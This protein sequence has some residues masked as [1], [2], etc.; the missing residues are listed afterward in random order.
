MAHN[1]QSAP[2]P[3]WSGPKR[4]PFCGCELDNGGEA[5]VRHVDVSEECHEGFERWRTNIVGDMKGEWTS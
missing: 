3:R 4:C 5:F 1:S 2:S